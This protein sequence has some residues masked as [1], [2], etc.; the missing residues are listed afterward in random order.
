MRKKDE[1]KPNSSISVMG[2]CAKELFRKPFSLKPEPKLR[3][4]GK[5]KKNIFTL[6]KKGLQ[7]YRMYDDEKEKSFFPNKTN[8][9]MLVEGDFAGDGQ[10]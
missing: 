3:E 6:W 5:L 4:G 1:E 2:I 7:M 10:I 8:I 9:S